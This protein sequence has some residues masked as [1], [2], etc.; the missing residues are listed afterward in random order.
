MGMFQLSPA[1]AI[2]TCLLDDPSGVHHGQ[3]A[4]SVG[5]DGQFDRNVGC[6]GIALKLGQS[7]PQ[8]S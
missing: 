1:Q 6:G 5:D 3:P 4:A 2:D 8:G 7:A